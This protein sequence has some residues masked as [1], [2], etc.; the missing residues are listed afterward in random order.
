[1]SSPDEE[2][3]EEESSQVPSPTKIDMEIVLKTFF[4]YD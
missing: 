1:L 4:H 3:A 2:M